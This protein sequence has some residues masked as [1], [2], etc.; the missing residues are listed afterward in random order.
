MFICLFI[1][2]LDIPVHARYV[3]S[4]LSQE[5]RAALVVAAVKGVRGQVV[6]ESV[7]IALVHDPPVAVL[8]L[9]FET[10]RF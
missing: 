7:R 9:D 1:V 10:V 8:H 3:E 4:A 6:S 2:V 5:D